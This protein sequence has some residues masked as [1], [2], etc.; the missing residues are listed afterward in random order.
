MISCRKT[1]ANDILKA[2]ALA[3]KEFN[4]E[5]D[6]CNNML[7]HLSGGTTMLT[8]IDN[9]DILCIIGAI[10]LWGGVVEFSSV[11]T[12]DVYNTR[13]SLARYLKKV[14]DK[15]IESEEIHRIQATAKLDFVEAQN[16]LEFLGFEKESV[17]K[18]YGSD[19]SDYIMYRKVK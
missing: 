11:F 8:I 6:N 9:E 14:L 3:K 17:L 5:T 18:M 19:K 15:F 12:V 2:T 1:N 13:I 16:F 7:S 10:P 4:S